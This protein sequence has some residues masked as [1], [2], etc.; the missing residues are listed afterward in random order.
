MGIFPSKWKQ[1]NIERINFVFFSLNFHW[2]GLCLVCGGGQGFYTHILLLGDKWETDHIGVCNL[3]KK[4][5]KLVFMKW[6]EL[7]TFSKEIGL[8]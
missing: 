6:E 7:H 4:G 1:I 8:N 2:L 3:A 5:K